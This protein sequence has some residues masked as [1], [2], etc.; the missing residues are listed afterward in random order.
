MLINSPNY[1]A[2]CDNDEYC[3]WK[4]VVPS[5]RQLII[6]FNEFHTEE[7]YDHLD[8][9]DGP[10][11]S[12]TKIATLS[13]SSIPLDIESSGN[14]LYLTFETDGSIPS[15]GFEIHYLEKGNTTV[16]L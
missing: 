14:S 8:V 7:D 16:L 15:R 12:S 2:D 13:G 4:I 3:Y 6:H 1:P 10:S 11:S 9:Y 5:G